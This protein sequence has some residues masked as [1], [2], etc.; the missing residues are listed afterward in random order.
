MSENTTLPQCVGFIG[1][2][3]MGKPMV[4]HLAKKLPAGS[5]IRV[6]DVVEAAVD[7][8]H[9]AFPEVIRKCAHAREVT[10]GSVRIATECRI[11]K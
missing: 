5:Q 7:D 9:S 8:I 3:A 2:G 6:H 11:H 10:E 1:L 4:S